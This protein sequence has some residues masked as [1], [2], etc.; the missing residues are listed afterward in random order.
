MALLTDQDCKDYL[1]IQGSAED[2]LIAALRV[3][4]LAQV[5][6]FIRRPITAELRTFTVTADPY[7]LTSRFYLPVYP[8]AAE[9]SSAGSADIVVTDAD[10]VDLIELNHF[11]DDLGRHAY[12]QVIFYEWSAEFCRYH[13]I[14][15]CLVEDDRDRFHFVQHDS[16]CACQRQGDADRT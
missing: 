7:R 1:K 15:W 16:L 14:S 8:V 6:Q 4:A 9:D 10:S 5:E 2:T 12:D 13:V 3:R 11:Y